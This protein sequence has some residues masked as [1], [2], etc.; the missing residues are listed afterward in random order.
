MAQRVFLAID[1]GASS[2]RHV[3]GLFD[4]SYLQLAEVHRFENG[5]VAAAGR[6]HWDLLAQWGQVL[7]G[8]R[9]AAATYASQVVS[10]GVDT[11]GVD[12]GLV[13][14]GDELL[15]NPVAY[16]DHRT[17]GMLERAF[18][19]VPRHEIF[20]HT[21]LQFMQFNSLY[22]L[23]AMQAAGSP[24]LDAAESLLMMPDLFHWLL[25]GVKSNEATNATTTQCYDPQARDWA[26]PLLAR[27]GLP[28]RIFGP[29]SGPGTSLGRLSRAVAGATNLPDLN[30]VLPGSHDTASAVVA[31]PASGAVSQAPAWCYISSGTWSLMG[32]EIPQPIVSDPCQTLNF[33]NEGGVGGTI[34]LLKNIAGLWLVQECRR[35]WNLKGRNLNWEDL[36]LLSAAAPPLRSLVN[37]DDPTLLAPD[38]MPAAIAAYCRRAGEPVPESE[39]AIVRTA[40]ESLALKYRQVLE[41]LERLL[42]TRIE[43]IHV[44]GGGTQNRQL[45]QATADACDRRVVAGPVE[46][47]AIGNVVVQAVAAGDI[48]SIAQA[49]EIIRHSFAVEEYEPTAAG[50]WAAAYQ[51][52]VKLP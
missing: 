3:A 18:A 30:V 26:W 17:E 21:G 6:L 4:G 13:G 11:W 28:K 50:P 19:T 32:V 7:R 46:A 10:V 38:D 22:Q 1:I 42:S 12:F 23:L 41:W 35:I 34:R 51:R 44:V 31:V 24:L 49:R 52:F 48:G 37:P 43:T 9:A 2:G 5:P 40:I 33:T 20:A 16:R 36:N 45:C 14:R 15:G 29:I 25:T 27:F 8:M 39:G 47:T